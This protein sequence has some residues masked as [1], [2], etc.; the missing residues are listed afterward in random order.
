MLLDS[1]DSALFA[2]SKAFLKDYFIYIFFFYVSF[3]FQNSTSLC[4]QNRIFIDMSNFLKIALL[5]PSLSTK[6]L[7][8]TALCIH[9]IVEPD[10]DQVSISI[11]MMA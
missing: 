10:P 9:S 6:R 1:L 3:L 4:R 2:N 11:M 7:S 5:S 8:T